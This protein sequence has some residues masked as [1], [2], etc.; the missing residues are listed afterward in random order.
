MCFP[1]EFGVLTID[2]Q[3]DTGALSSAIS[4]ADFE[5]IKRVAPQKT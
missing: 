1:M 4:E 2:G 5:Q 3:I